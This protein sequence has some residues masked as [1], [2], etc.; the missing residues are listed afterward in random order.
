MPRILYIEDDEN[1][2]FMLS[3]RLGRAGFEVQVADDGGGGVDAAL[4]APPDLV[5][6]D[7]GLPGMDGW[8]TSRKLKANAVTCAVPIVAVSSHSMSGDR[9]RAIAAGCDDYVT[10][11][12]DF[13][14]LLAKIR[15]LLPARCAP[16]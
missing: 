8:E 14:G 4:S 13:P 10:K 5:L 6:L 16:G 12:I 15:T 2:A 1:S 11:P 7:L 9:E 3:R